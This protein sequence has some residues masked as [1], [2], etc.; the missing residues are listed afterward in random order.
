MKLIELT[1][2]DRQ[3]KVYINK[4]Q[5]FTFFYSK[6][7]ACTLVEASGGGMI[8]VSESPEEIKQ[9]LEKENTNE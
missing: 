3:T 7:F 1:E 2:P 9:E 6:Q 4:S 5:I 8:K